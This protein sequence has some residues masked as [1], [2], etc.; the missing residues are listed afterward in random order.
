[1]SK[2]T[3]PSRFLAMPAKRAAVRRDAS[4]DDTLDA[5]VSIA[6]LIARADGWVQEVERRQLLDFVDHYDRLAPFD[7]AEVL[8]RFDRRVVEL[9]RPNGP[10]SAFRR[11]SRYNDHPTAD[12]MLSVGREIAAA[13]C[14]LDPREE[15]LLRLFRTRL[16]GATA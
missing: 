16:Q 12:L 11:L 3:T 1:M 8:A 5:I 14:R 9:R 7:H 2:P 10:F 4:Q 15:Q 13:D 6:A